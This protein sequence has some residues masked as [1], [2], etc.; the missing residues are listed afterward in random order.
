MPTF[1]VVPVKGRLELTRCLVGQLA[2]SSYESL[3]VL[4]NGSTDGTW[5]WLCRQPSS[6]HLE[7][8]DA[9]GLGIYAMWNLGVSLARRRAPLCN[10]AVLNNDIRVGPKFLDEL[11]AGLRS[12]RDLWAVSANYD[13]REIDGVEYVRASFKSSGFAGFAFMARGEVFEAVSFD[14]GFGWWYGDDDFLAQIAARGGRVGIVGAATVEHVNGGGQ[15]AQYDRERLSAI[16]RDRR[17]MWS[18]WGHF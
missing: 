16:E 4:D 18:K 8:V 10:V 11:S 2:T 6:L 17:R 14:E 9:R 3:L 13:G 12:R 7:P 5:D 1:V 15:T